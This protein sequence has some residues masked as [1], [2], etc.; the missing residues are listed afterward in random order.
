MSGP[1]P[2]SIAR[3]ARVVAAWRISRAAL[4]TAAAT[5]L[6]FPV[7]AAVS[8]DASGYFRV[9]RLAVKVPVMLARIVFWSNSCP[10][11]GVAR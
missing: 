4:T 9:T 6:C 11:T 10:A 3:T 8:A 5:G 1:R 7:T 2:P